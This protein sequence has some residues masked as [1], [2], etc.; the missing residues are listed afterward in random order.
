MDSLAGRLRRT[1][2]DEEQRL[3]A[4]TEQSAESRTGTSEGWSRKQELGHL[5]DSAVNNRVRFIGASLDGNYSGPS[6]DGVGW[7]E[8]G[9][10]AGQ[11]WADLI[12]TWALLNNGMVLAIERIPQERLSALCRIGDANPVTLEFLIEDYILHMQHHLD[13]IL[14]REKQTEY[15]GAAIGI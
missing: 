4:I 12:D 7:V 2:A 1:V 8:L 11:R 10:Y 9:G 3:R 14:A 15:P 6:Y 13:H 5:I